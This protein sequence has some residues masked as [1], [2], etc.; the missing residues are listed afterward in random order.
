MFFI[1]HLLRFS[2][3]LDLHC[4]Q[5]TRSRWESVLF[6]TANRLKLGWQ[7]LLNR[8]W[9]CFYMSMKKWDRCRYTDKIMRKFYVHEWTFRPRYIPRIYHHV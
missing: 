8:V 3:F 5:K 2:I 7:A 4:M 6:A 1:F 9:I